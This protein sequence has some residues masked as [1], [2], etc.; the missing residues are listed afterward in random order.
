MAEWVQLT[1]RTD[2]AKIWVNIEMATLVAPDGIGSRITLHGRDKELFTIESPDIVMSR[3]SYDAAR[4]VL[5]DAGEGGRPT[6]EARGP[7]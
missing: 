6:V 4:Q 2:R 7:P 1:S 3:R 5:A